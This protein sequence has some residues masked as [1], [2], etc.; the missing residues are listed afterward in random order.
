M[1]KFIGVL[2]LRFSPRGTGAPPVVYYNI[3][4]MADPAD[5]RDEIELLLKQIANDPTDLGLH[6]QLR[7]ASL[8][9]KATGGRDLGMFTKLKL[10]LQSA[11]S[12]QGLLDGLRLWSFDPGNPDRAVSILQALENY[13]REFPSANIAPL[14]RW[15]REILKRMNPD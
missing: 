15:L 1:I 5:F 2:F 11:G 12:L 13:A 6:R 3:P 9:H 14:R 7:N 10:N 4:P 8:K